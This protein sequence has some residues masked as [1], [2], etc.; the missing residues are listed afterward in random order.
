MN[1]GKITVKINITTGLIIAFILVYIM[2]LVIGN[3]QIIT[4]FAMNGTRAFNMGEYYRMLTSGFLH[5]SFLHLFMNSSFIFTVG[6]IVEE[7]IGKTRYIC[8]VIAT[9]ISASIA[10]GI[11]DIV[12]ANQTLTLGASG[13]GFGLIGLIVGFAVMYPNRYYKGLAINILSNVFLYAIVYVFIINISWI[14]HFGGF[15]GGL[16]TGLVLNAFFRKEE[17]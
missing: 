7:M 9:M 15:V 11:L 17:W 2:Q 1:V 14:G 5:G 8:L 12:Q 3:N 4:A 6:N 10:V 13:F 16:I